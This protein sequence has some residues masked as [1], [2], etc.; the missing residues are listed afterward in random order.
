MYLFEKLC[1]LIF[2]SLSLLIF[3]TTKKTKTHTFSTFTVQQ[4]LLFH[5]ICHESRTVDEAD[6]LALMYVLSLAMHFI[7]VSLLNI[8]TPTHSKHGSLYQHLSDYLLRK[9]FSHAVSAFSFMIYPWN[10]L[11]KYALR[12][13]RWWNKQNVL[14]HKH[15]TSFWLFQIK[16]F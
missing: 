3:C 9:I 4:L 5:V 15:L 13:S 10:Y 14:I 12:M 11:G 8:H 16:I 2:Y 1:K 7:Y 6:W